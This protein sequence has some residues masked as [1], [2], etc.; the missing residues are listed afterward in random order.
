M[1]SVDQHHLYQSLDY[2]SAVNIN[3][4]SISIS[5]C[6]SNACTRAVILDTSV[7]LLIGRKLL[8]LIYCILYPMVSTKFLLEIRLQFYRL[9]M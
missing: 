3:E 8:Y 4:N 6:G 2:K 9:Q 7:T 1:L 5:C